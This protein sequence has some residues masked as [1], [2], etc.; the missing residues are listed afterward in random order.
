M[1]LEQMIASYSK[2][3]NNPQWEEWDRQWKHVHDWQTYAQKLRPFWNQLSLEARCAVVAVCEE[4]A[5]RE[6]WD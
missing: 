2:D 1:T 4:A 6:D 3:A 5:S